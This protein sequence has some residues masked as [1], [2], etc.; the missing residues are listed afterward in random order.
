M[1]AILAAGVLAA[2][3]GVIPFAQD[4]GAQQDLD[5]ITRGEGVAKA[6]D[7]RFMDTAGL[8]G[9]GYVTAK[10]GW[11]AAT[12]AN[13]SCYVALAMSGSGKLFVAT[14]KAPGAVELTS[15]SDTSCVSSAVLDGIVGHLN[16]GAG[17]GSSPSY[18]IT[19]ARMVSTWD[20]SIVP[21]YGDPCTRITLPLAGTVDATI[22]WGDGSAPEKVTAGLPVHDYT[23]TPGPQTITI[24]GTFTGWNGDDWPTWSTE[25]LTEVTQWGETGTT[26]AQGGFYSA[27]HLTDV[28]RMPSTVTSYYGLF[29]SATS[30]NGDISD[31]DTSNVTDMSWMFSGSAFNQDISGWN[32]SKVTEMGMMFYNA[33]AFNQDIS[34][35][36]TSNVSNMLY[37]FFAN[38]SFDQDLSNWNVAK[39]GETYHMYFNGSSVLTNDHIPYAFREPTS[40]TFTPVSSPNASATIIDAM[41]AD[42]TYKAA[43]EYLAGIKGVFMGDFST[44]WAWAGYSGATSPA[45]E[46]YTTAHA[47]MYNPLGEYV[48]YD[49]ILNRA[50]SG[51]PDLKTA[52]W[53]AQNAFENG[54]TIRLQQKYVDALRAQYQ[55]ALDAPR[56]DPVTAVPAATYTPIPA[57]AGTADQVAWANAQLGYAASQF[58][59]YERESQ[60]RNDW[61]MIDDMGRARDATP[62]G[63]AYKAWVD[64]GQRDYSTEINNGSNSTLVNLAGTFGNTMFDFKYFS[65]GT[66]ANIKPAQQAYVDAMRA[67]YAAILVEANK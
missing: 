35:W 40:V 8:D 23:G 24:D 29:D 46:A 58:T 3:F 25:C 19:A 2:I 18:D 61:T 34:G 20:T 43:P 17:S 16:P 51:V 39:V 21:A 44:Y 32:T 50:D 7:S 48:T 62:A 33:D 28:N 54:G 9:A 5:A 45:R 15:T 10:P 52:S 30:F 22:D 57:S 47:S 64:A 63:Q 53:N 49:A 4:K 13:G 41:N 65:S 66:A 38:D 42:L 56:I 11:N 1:V 27:T 59:L 6:K 12:N 26:D 37:M 14:D 31:W 55:T 67:Y 36:D 60:L